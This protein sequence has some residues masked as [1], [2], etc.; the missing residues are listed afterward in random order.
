VTG[1]GATAAADWIALFERVL[2]SEGHEPGMDF[3]VDRRRVTSVPSRQ[4]VDDIVRYY[5][6]HGAELGRC[7]LASVTDDDAAYGMNRVAEVFSQQ[8][9]ATVRVFRDGERLPLAPPGA[10]AGGLAGPA[11]LRSA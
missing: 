9:T 5:A 8:T 10:G 1:E 2:A 3:L 4:T 11:L 6:T 7:R